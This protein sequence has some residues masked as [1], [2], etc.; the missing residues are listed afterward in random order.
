MNEKLISE[1]MSQNGLFTYENAEIDKLQTTGELV[2]FR[3]R[4]RSGFEGE[5]HQIPLLDIVAWV[6]SLLPR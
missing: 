4:D 2:I 6:F 3:E 5:D 1:Y